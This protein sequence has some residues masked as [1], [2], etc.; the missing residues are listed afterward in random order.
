VNEEEEEEDNDDD[1]VFDLVVVGSG[2]V[3]CAAAKWAL[4]LCPHLKKVALVG[5]LSEGDGAEWV[6]EKKKET[7]EG[8]EGGGGRERG[9][10]RGGGG[11]ENKAAGQVCDDEKEAD[12]KI[13]EA[14]PCWFGCSADEGRI[15]RRLD[16]DPTWAELAVRS[17]G[18]YNEIK[19][20]AKTAFK[21]QHQEQQQLRR[22]QQQK[23]RGQRLGDNGLLAGGGNDE[24]VDGD[25]DMYETTTTN[26]VG[27]LNISGGCK[28]NGNADD[29]AD[30]DDEDSRSPWCFHLPVGFLA[31]GDA[32]GDYVKRVQGTAGRLGLPLTQLPGE[33]KGGEKGGHK[34]EE[35]LVVNKPD[36][37][38]DRVVEE[39]EVEVNSSQGTTTLPSRF[40]FLSFSAN[41]LPPLPLD[42]LPGTIPPNKPSPPPALSSP[43]PPPPPPP[44]LSF[45]PPSVM[46]LLEE[47]GAG[48]VSA[49]RLVQAQRA[50]FE[51]LGGIVLGDVAVGKVECED[52]KKELEKKE[53]HSSSNSGNG[54]SSSGDGDGGKGSG[55]GSSQGYRLVHL[56]PLGKSESGVSSSSGSSSSSTSRKVLKA[57]RVLVATNAFTNF[58]PLLPQKLKLILNA[59]TTVRFVLNDEDAAR[60]AE[61]PS[62]VFIGNKPAPPALPL[63]ANQQHNDSAATTFPAAGASEIATAAAVGVGVGD[64]GSCYVLPPLLYPK[65]SVLPCGSS[66]QQPG[67]NTASEGEKKQHPSKV[68][69]S[70]GAMCMKI[71][72]GK[73][74]ERELTTE[75]QVL[76][77]YVAVSIFLSYNDL[78]SS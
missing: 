6:V 36:S 28:D 78:V 76:R 64:D 40:P 55:S 48:C 16:P 34:K 1:D 57:R 70:S 4:K 24:K 44:P 25:D 39:E 2:L 38:N 3:G 53:G 69:S 13:E 8:G 18:R 75:A 14:L 31:V 22:R 12:D 74:W 51:S 27:R 37:D 68:S 65:L 10:G 42:S 52:L 21:Q 73:F 15:T 66:T 47:G 41:P 45:F 17:L 72:H 19:R 43:P 33:E 58:R 60:L 49:R 59:Q 32:H 71:G 61:M 29:D 5:P 77:W 63:P 9:G 11:E 7:E 46:A 23:E 54:D 30:A 62:M 35:A 20:E 67:S 56:T 26:I 50:I